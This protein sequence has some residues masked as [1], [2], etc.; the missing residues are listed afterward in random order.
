M[1]G[2]RIVLIKYRS[3]IIDVCL[4][5]VCPCSFIKGVQE[6]IHQS[7]FIVIQPNCEVAFIAGHSP[8]NHVLIGQYVQ[9]HIVFQFELYI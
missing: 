2:L 3:Q 9:F 7:S 6:G 4:G 8:D 5:S 1:N